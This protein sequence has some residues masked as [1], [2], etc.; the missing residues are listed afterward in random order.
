MITHK[1]S[2]KVLAPIS[3]ENNIE[4]YRLTLAG[5]YIWAEELKNVFYTWAPLGG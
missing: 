2:K 3:K 5:M 4:I 1:E